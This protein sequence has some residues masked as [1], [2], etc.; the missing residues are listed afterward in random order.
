MGRKQQVGGISCGEGQQ[1][2]SGG[3]GE[4]TAA[5]TAMV[6]ATVRDSCKVES[7]GE[8]QQGYDDWLA[9]DVQDKIC[10]SK[11]ESVVEHF[12]EYRSVNVPC[13]KVLRS[14]YK[15]TDLVIYQHMI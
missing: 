2:G 7:C 11:L 3:E 9:R 5:S 14:T 1:K 12:K 15:N 8:G 4:Q 6:T 13:E 10:N